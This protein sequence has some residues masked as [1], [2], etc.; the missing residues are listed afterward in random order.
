MATSKYPKAMNPDEQNFKRSG[1]KM[2][3]EEDLLKLRTAMRARESSNNY[4]AVNDINYVGAYQMGAAAL[5]DLGFLKKGSSKE[6]NKAVFNPE[7]WTGK[8]N[9]NS[10][11][12]FL[13]NE[14]VQDDAFNAYAQQNFKTLGR[15]GTIGASSTPEEVAGYL[16]ASHLLGAGGASKSLDA[17][18]KNNVTGRTY[19]NIAKEAINTPLPEN[20]KLTTDELV[21]ADTRGQSLAQP[22]VNTP[23]AEPQGTNITEPI[24]LP[25]LKNKEDIKRVQQAI[26]VKADGIWGPQ[27]QQAWKETNDLFVTPTYREEGMQSVD[28][29]ESDLANPF[30]SVKRWFDSI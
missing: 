6:G 10:L 8:G 15:I 18:D 30:F 2:L 19:F 11:E 29:E 22:L 5:E 28:T 4:M 13:K 23:S 9:I 1:A 3:S 21:G 24:G 20:V 7:N 25:D 16:A 17:K 27:S 12:A 14:K 26:G